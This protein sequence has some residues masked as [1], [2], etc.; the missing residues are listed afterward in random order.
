M[1]TK[2]SK[3]VIKSVWRPMGVSTG[4]IYGGGSSELDWK[5]ETVMDDEGDSCVIRGM[6]RWLISMRLAK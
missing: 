1:I 6:W 2:K 3:E 5:S 4:R